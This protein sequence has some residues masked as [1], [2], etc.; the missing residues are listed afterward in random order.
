MQ[1]PDTRDEI[2]P[3]DFFEAERFVKAHIKDST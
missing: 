2:S 1:W 3:K